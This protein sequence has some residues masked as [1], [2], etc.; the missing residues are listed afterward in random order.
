MQSGKGDPACC[1]VRALDA[2]A[3]D[4]SPAIYSQL[5]VIDSEILAATSTQ[6]SFACLPEGSSGWLELPGTGTRSRS[7]RFREWRAREMPLMG[8]IPAVKSWFVSNNIRH[9]EPQ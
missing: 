6:G 9:A 8:S 5:L 4:G 2:R 1:S 7:L 3:Y